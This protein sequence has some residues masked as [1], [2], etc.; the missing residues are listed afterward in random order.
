MEQKTLKDLAETEYTFWRFSQSQKGRSDESCYADYNTG[1]VTESEE[2]ELDN[3]L[4]FVSN[5]DISTCFMYGDVLNK[6][7]FDKSNDKFKEIENYP[8]KRFNNSFREYKSF[9]LLV[10]KQYSL[11]K[12][13]TIRMI[14][15]MV[16]NN[17]QLYV[18]FAYGDGTGLAGYLK[19]WGFAESETLVLF[20]RS[21]YTT[22]TSKAEIMEWI[23]EY[24]KE[25]KL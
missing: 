11:A 21:K 12:L 20:L 15:D 13:E 7:C 1:L 10:E 23:D 14:F 5:E 25:N 2:L 17:K 22:N 4:S 8:T 16:S 24:I 3:A 9:K 19:K 6:L 18:L